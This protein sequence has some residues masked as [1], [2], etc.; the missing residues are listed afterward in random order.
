MLVNFFNHRKQGNFLKFC[1]EYWRFNEEYHLT[2]LCI[3]FYVVI[4]WFFGVDMKLFWRQES[5][6][7]KT[8]FCRTPSFRLWIKYS[9]C[10]A[11]YDSICI[12]SSI[13]CL[14][15]VYNVY[16]MTLFVDFY[17]FLP[18]FV[19][20]YFRLTLKLDWNRPDT[21]ETLIL[22]VHVVLVVYYWL[23]YDSNL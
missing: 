12:L 5:G 15:Y 13:R 9:F 1:V 8:K 16:I 21:P 14:Y 20:L 7:E 22:L 10:L 17:S 23:W 6:R 19:F 11:L 2:L 4:S 18:I 3:G